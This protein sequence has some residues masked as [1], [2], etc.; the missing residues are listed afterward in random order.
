MDN[1]DMTWAWVSD[2]NSI[3]SK[4]VE[5]LERKGLIR[6]FGRDEWLL[7]QI[8]WNGRNYVKAKMQQK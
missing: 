5:S 7:A 1:N 2:E 4:I 8:T 3:D 6:V